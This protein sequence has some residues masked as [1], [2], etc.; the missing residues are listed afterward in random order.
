MSML[1][2]KNVAHEIGHVSGAGLG[3][4]ISLLKLMVLENVRLTLIPEKIL[5]HMSVRRGLKILIF[6][7][8]G[9]E[10]LGFLKDARRGAVRSKTQ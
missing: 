10:N 1:W 2:Y 7:P 9:F 8:H 3:P 6:K 4:D 5:E